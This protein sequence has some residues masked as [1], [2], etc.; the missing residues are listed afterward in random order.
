MGNAAHVLRFLRTKS[1]STLAQTEDN[2]IITESIF[3]SCNSTWCSVTGESMNKND[4][5]PLPTKLNAFTA[6]LMNRISSF[7]EVYAAFRPLHRKVNHSVQVYRLAKYMLSIRN[8]SM[9]TKQQIRSLGRGHMRIGVQREHLEVFQDCFLISLCHMLQI[10]VNDKRIHNWRILFEFVIS[11][12]Y[13]EKINFISHFT[14]DPVGAIIPHVAMHRNN[15]SREV[16]FGF[17][18]NGKPLQRRRERD[19]WDDDD[20]S[21]SRNPPAADNG[22][23]KLRDDSSHNRITSKS[24]VHFP[25]HLQVGN[26]DSNQN[27][28]LLCL[29]AAASADANNTNNANNA[30]ANALSTAETD[31]GTREEDDLGVTLSEEFDLTIDDETSLKALT[32]TVPVSHCERQRLIVLRQTRIL[33]SSQTDPEYDAILSQVAQIAMVRYELATSSSIFIIDS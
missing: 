16:S 5:P 11:Q 12:M 26:E 31:L 14:K 22:E 2:S 1:T 21:N 23:C 4:P 17:Q 10:R 8:N 20:N 3:Q 9:S 13:F 32:L 18:S 33:D 7:S 27:L 30:H 25:S 15:E 29:A 28:S 6:D 19:Y 24:K